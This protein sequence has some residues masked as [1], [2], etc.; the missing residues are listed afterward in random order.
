MYFK[1][2]LYL[3]VLITHANLSSYSIYYIKC[4]INVFNSSLRS[5]ILYDPISKDLRTK[6]A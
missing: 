6:D 2:F 1:V 4:Q 3:Y 5:V